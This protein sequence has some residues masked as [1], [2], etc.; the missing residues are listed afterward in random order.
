L[1]SPANVANNDSGGG[2]VPN[3]IDGEHF[4]GFKGNNTEIQHLEK[5][6][7]EI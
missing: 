1:K 7:P 3:L 2:V 4:L 5:N 6:Q